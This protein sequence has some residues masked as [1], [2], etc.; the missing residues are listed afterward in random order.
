M[1]IYSGNTEI[2]SLFLGGTQ[3][4]NVYS[5]A[6]LVWSGETLIYSQPLPYTGSGP[7][8]TNAPDNI[9]SDANGYRLTPS[10]TFTQSAW[11]GNVVTLVIGRTY[12]MDIIISLEAGSY[13]GKNFTITGAT[14]ASVDCNTVGSKSV[15]FVAVEAGAFPLGMR[16]GN[17]NTFDTLVWN[18]IE[19]WDLG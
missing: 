13:S 10:N 6:N 11:T 3:I 14:G 17:A 9:T 8:A 2:A 1:A 4:E 18:S 12:R 16:V 19:I 15:T 5:G 7:W